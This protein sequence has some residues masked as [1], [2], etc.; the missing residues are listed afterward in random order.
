MS[1][2]LQEKAFG[3]ISEDL[4]HDNAFVYKVMSKVCEYVKGNYQH[5][6]KVR[7][8]SDGCVAQYKNYKKVLNLCHHYSDL[9]WKQNGTSLQPVIKNL[10]LTG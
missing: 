7:Y 4:K 2:V 3:F 10:L 1:N 8:F 6:T 5:I 9:I